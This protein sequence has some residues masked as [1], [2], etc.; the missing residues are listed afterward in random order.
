MPVPH[1]AT[2]DWP[3][4]SENPDQNIGDQRQQKGDGDE[5]KHLL[6]L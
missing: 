5:D 4:E 6:V 1:T 2:T 3:E